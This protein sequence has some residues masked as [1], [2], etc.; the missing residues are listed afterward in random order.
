[1]IFFFN[2]ID[3]ILM[4]ILMKNPCFVS[5]NLTKRIKLHQIL[6]DWD[7]IETKRTREPI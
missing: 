2:V 3:K 4:S 7:Q 6:E 1:M 5:R